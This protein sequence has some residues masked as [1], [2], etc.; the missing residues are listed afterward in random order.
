ME[1]DSTEGDSDNEEEVIEPEGSAEEEEMNIED[2][3]N[4]EENSEKFIK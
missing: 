2:V 3:E 1:D 4:S